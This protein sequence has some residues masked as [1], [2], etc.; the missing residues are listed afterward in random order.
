MYFDSVASERAKRFVCSKRFASDNEKRSFY[1]CPLDTSDASDTKGTGV[2]TA[3]RCGDSHTCAG[4]VRVNSGNVG[5]C[6]RMAC[7]RTAYS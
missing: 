3:P 6:F 7:A 2:L 1:R 4:C 5:A